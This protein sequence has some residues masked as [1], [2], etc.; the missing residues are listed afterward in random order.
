MGRWHS[1]VLRKPNHVTASGVARHQHL[2][3]PAESID[4]KKDLAPRQIGE[5]V[6]QGIEIASMRALDCSENAVSDGCMRSHDEILPPR[7]PHS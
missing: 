1:G 4:F 5:T 3:L 2:S 6:R 7:P